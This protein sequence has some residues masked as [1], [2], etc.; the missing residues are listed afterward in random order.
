DTPAETHVGPGGQAANVAA[1]AAWLGAEARY[2]GRRADDAAGR[3]VAAGL[4]ARGVEVLGPV[5]PGR[6]G[7]VVSLL[8]GGGERTLASD[9]GVSPDIRPEELEPAWLAG[10]A[11]L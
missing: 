3:L 7:T 5:G 9:R 4:A 2:V 11:A 10:C 6:T 1:W 8:D